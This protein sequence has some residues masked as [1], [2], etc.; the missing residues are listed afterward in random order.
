M[1]KLFYV[2]GASGAG[3]DTLMNYARNA[4]QSTEKIVFAHR[5]ITRS[6][7][8]G[9]ENH[10]SLTEQEFKTRLKQGLFSLHWGS[11]NNL[12]GIGI[13]IDLWMDK[14]FNVVINGS[15][16]YLP[17]AQKIYPNIIPILIAVSP[18]VLEERLLLRGRES[19]EEISK[20]IQRTQD[21]NVT[22][23]NC[24]QIQNDSSVEDAGGKLLEIISAA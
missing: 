21:L 19:Q 1:S 3:K 18:D 10:I 14:G 2:M 11:H 15:R 20:R 6:P 12:Y 13:E 4:V 17:T 16:E 22:I 8:S 24:Q 9:N 5:Y 23:E 7:F